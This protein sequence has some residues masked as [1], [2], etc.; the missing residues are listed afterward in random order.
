MEATIQHTDN[1]IVAII[2]GVLILLFALMLFHKHDFITT[3]TIPQVEVLQWSADTC[4][5]RNSLLKT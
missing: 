4:W 1:K 3:S 5:V 2:A